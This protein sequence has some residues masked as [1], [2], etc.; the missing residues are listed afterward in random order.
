MATNYMA[1]LVS[2]RKGCFFPLAVS[3]FGFACAAY[4]CSPPRKPLISLPREKISAFRIGNQ[5]FLIRSFRMETNYA[6]S[7]A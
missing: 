7:I 1:E 4:Q 6:E 5:Q 2:V 3:I